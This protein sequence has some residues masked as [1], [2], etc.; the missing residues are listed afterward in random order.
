M[1]IDKPFMVN[2][3]EP[4]ATDLPKL[5]GL[6]KLYESVPVVIVCASPNVTCVHVEPSVE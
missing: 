1:G 6:E 3:E 2:A 5:A 4:A